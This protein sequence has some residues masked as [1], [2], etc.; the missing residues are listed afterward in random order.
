[1]LG[2]AYVF[3]LD[4]R[5][6]VG[7]MRAGWM[8]W[9]STMGTNVAMALIVVG[10]MSLVGVGTFLLVQLP[11]TLIAAS[12]GVWLFVYV[13]HQF[14]DTAPG[15]NDNDLAFYTRPLLYGSPH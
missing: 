1:M 2:P 13:Q 5:L 6:A 12:V 9:I 3:L 8:P 15:P 7:F 4:Y 11:I 14:E 10:M